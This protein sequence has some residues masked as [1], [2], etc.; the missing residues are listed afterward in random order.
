MEPID[1]ANNTLIWKGHIQR[2]RQAF[3]HPKLKGFRLHYVR[4]VLHSA[5]KNAENN[6]DR[7]LKYPSQT[8]SLEH[9][10]WPDD[11][12]YDALLLVEE[13]HCAGGP[14]TSVGTVKYPKCAVSIRVEHTK[15][16]SCVYVRGSHGI[17]LEEEREAVPARG[18]SEEVCFLA[19]NHLTFIDES[20]SSV[21]KSANC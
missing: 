2:I 19:S 10:V 1:P 15:V 16:E 7:K 20:V 8:A 14:C 13:L 18:L 9:Y 4:L 6:K 3:Q 11:T 5:D 17:D 12:P 21:L